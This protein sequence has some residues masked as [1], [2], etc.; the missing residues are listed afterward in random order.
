M[1][2]VLFLGHCI[3]LVV[4]HSIEDCTNIN[5]LISVASELVTHFK[6]CELNHL[7]STTLKQK[8]DTRWN[9]IFEM[10][11]SIDIN[12]KQIEDVL[13]ERKES[14]DYLDKLDRFLLKS[15]SEVL[16]SFKR[17]SERLS[18]DEVP[19]LHLVLPWINKLKSNCEVRA[20]DSNEIKKFKS[21]LLTHIDEKVWLTAFHDIATF[22]HPV[23]KN[24]LVSLFLEIVHLIKFSN[25]LVV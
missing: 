19:T 8:C 23:T 11:H 12:F 20:D 4:Q 3:N 7:L 9:S 25:F 15:I 6:K 17:A 24:L 21:I 2:L 16:C 1:I 10:I 13:L 14:A 18:M 5:L 22:L